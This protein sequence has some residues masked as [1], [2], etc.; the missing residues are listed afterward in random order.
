VDWTAGPASAATG[1]APQLQ[2]SMQAVG[3]AKIAAGSV[4]KIRGVVKN[5]G[6]V[7]AYRVRAVLDSDNPIF[8]ENEMVFGKIAPGESKSYDLS[9][10]IPTSSFTRTDEIKATLVTQ[11]GSAKAIGGDLLVNIDGKARPMFAYTYQTIDD[12]K[13][14]NHDGQVQRGEQARMLVTVKNIGQGKA[15]HTEAVLRNGT[16]QEGILISAGRFEAKDMAPG[17]SKTFSFVY[18]VR[19]EFKGDDFQLELSVGDTTLGES[20]TDKIKI[21]VA[22]PGPAPETQAGTATVVKDDAPLHEAASEGALVV[23]RAPK[24]SSFKVSGKL[25]T[26]TR[27]DLDAGRSAFISTADLK[28]GGAV[29]GALKPEW[30]VTPPQLTVTAPTVA[31]GDTVH[32]KGHASDDHLVRDVYVRVWNRNAKIPVKKVYYQPNRTVGDRTKMDFEADIP[33][34]AGSNL[35]Q[36]FARESNDV[37]SLQTVVVLKR[38]GDSSVV[39]QPWDASNNPGAGQQQR[40]TKTK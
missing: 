34:W 38:S 1:A 5:T 9:V 35:V 22:P 19:P 26:Y 4:T 3:D 18:E 25:G 13:A 28:S 10:K 31:A 33:L 21:K 8:D 16:G 6:T 37:Q 7:P 40:T 27:L 11:R 32:I 2:M 14:D 15:M 36:V 20:V 29:H 12:Q 23:G 24:G 17:E 30:Q 39:A